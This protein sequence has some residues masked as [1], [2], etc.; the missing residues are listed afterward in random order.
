MDTA[1]DRL[2][3]VVRR[4]GRHALTDPVALRAALRETGNRFDAVESDAL[5]T[6]AGS[7]ELAELRKRGGL[8]TR[9]ATDAAHAAADRIAARTG[10]P[11]ARARW[12][13]AALVS[14][15]LPGPPRQTRT[16][17]LLTGTTTP[18]R[19]WDQ[20]PT[21]T[22]CAGTA[23]NPTKRLAGCRPRPGTGDGC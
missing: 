7:P 12:A 5:T 22:G 9:P 20:P 11:P 15:S 14:A 10:L 16:K 2:A 8:A 13:V 23:R 21:T 4:Y 18:S 3:E 17:L 1:D 19:R 6:V